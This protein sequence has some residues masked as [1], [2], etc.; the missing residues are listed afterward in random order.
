MAG[1]EILEELGRGAVG[2]VYRARHRA[3]N[4]LVALKMI[5]AGPHLAPET[6]QRFRVEAQAIARLQHSNIVQVHEVGEQAGCPYLALE[7]VEGQNLARWI[8]GVPHPADQAARIVATLAHAVDYAHHHGVIHRDL[9]PANVLLAADGTAKITD[10][11]LAKILPGPGVAEERMTQSGMILGTPSYIAPEQARGQAK[12][13][14]P[15]VDIYSLGA[16]LYELLTGRPPFQGTSP[17]DTLLQAAHQEPVPAARL[18]AHL[19]RDL[20]TI[21]MKCLEKDPAKRYATA[22]ALAADLEHFLSDEP[23]A[24]RPVGPMERSLRWLRRRPA[25]VV[26]MAAS[27]VLALTLAGVGLWWR[28]QRSAEV[29]AAVVNAEDDL[30]DAEAFRQRY[31]FVNAAAALGRAKLRLGDEGPAELRDRIAR[32]S[33][34]LELVK[35]LD[36]IRLNRV[37][38]VTVVK[39]SLVAEGTEDRTPPARK[40][41]AAFREAAVG[42]VQDDPAEVA[43]RVTASPVHVALVA[44]LDDWASCALDRDQRAWV[45]AVARRADPNPWRDRVRDPTTWDNLAVLTDLAATA[46]L[47]EQPPQLLAALGRR[48]RGSDG[49]ATAFL[50]RVVLA[51][52]A[53]F[54]VN[55]D[56][57]YALYGTAPVEALAYFRTALASRPES[58]PVHGGLGVLYFHRGQI[59]EARDQF[60]YAARLA[61]GDPWVH[62]DLGM[63]LLAEDRTYEAVTHLREAVRLDPDYASAHCNLGLALEAERRLDE[64]RDEGLKALRL[65]PRNCAAKLELQGLLLRLG[66]GADL[67]LAWQKDLAANPP[68]HDAW[69]GYAELC[70]FLGEEAEYRR[71]R[72]DLLAHFRASTE[73]PV[74]ER[75]GRACLLLPAS[76]DELRQAVALIDRAVAAREAS[77][78]WHYPYFLFAKG[79]AEYRL[80][81]FESAITLMEGRAARVMGPAPRLVLAMALHQRGQKDGARETLAAA[82]LSFDWSVAKA[83]SRNFAWIAHVLR[84]EAEAMILPDLPAFLEGKHQPRDNDERLALLG[85]CQF[86]NLRGAEAGLYAAAFAADPKLAED[87]PAGLRY[88]AARAAAVVGG[89]GGADGARLSAE[90]RARWRKQARAWLRADLDAWVRNLE[91]R[92]AADRAQFHGTLAWW[93]R[94]PDLAGLRDSYELEK[95]PRDER[96]ECLALWTDLAVRIERILTRPGEFLPLPLDKA[97]TVVS[98]RG[99]F[100]DEES[101]AERLIFDDWSPKEFEG[102]P[103]HLIDPRGDRVPNAVLLYGPLG[104]V[105]PRMPRSV[106]VPCHV[107]ARAIHFLSGVSGWGHPLGER[108]SVSMI[109]RLHYEGGMTEDHR[110]KNGEHFADYTRRV[111]VPRSKFA[112]LLRTQQIRYLAV[113]PQRKDMI[114]LIELIKGPNDTAPIV[115]AITAEKR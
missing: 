71:A 85:V 97:A 84:R 70:L 91:S 9:K 23:I 6:R 65:D 18:V 30:R 78:R 47:A 114:E 43:A 89:G 28:W 5:L 95:L 37:L 113:L 90:E 62:N 39:R 10:F 53:D 56:L 2:V 19:P 57:A 110:L 29:Q 3:L 52:P 26:A 11:G 38:I 16:M 4:R 101:P 108:G 106:R 68:E 41:E 8:A 102:V 35:R 82:V 79:L 31:D 54:W 81:R 51:H 59:V 76:G 7:L 115:M 48:L 33:H 112:F 1:Y 83:D 63:V 73:P 88:R 46:P 92:P 75:T 13:A 44:A 111:D 69:F 107:A 77:Y 98:T 20:D 15:G 22:G 74:A 86:K 17:M 104:K 40:Y 21:C 45:L 50:R 67:R 103:F 93:R 87:L 25:L 61:P 100:Y 64:S 80:G 24:A 58:V 36:A 60:Q 94:D 72:R 42:T 109:V 66:R 55:L 32:A 99:M 34:D 27:V 96:Q 49:D 105:P 14:G 12:E